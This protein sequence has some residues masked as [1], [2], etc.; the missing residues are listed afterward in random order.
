LHNRT[1][2]FRNSVTERT[3]VWVLVISALF[4]VV[5][6]AA[7]AIP[8]LTTEAILGSIGFLISLVLTLVRKAE[9]ERTF[10]FGIIKNESLLELKYSE[11][12]RGAWSKAFGSWTTS[13]SVLDQEEY[14]QKEKNELESKKKL[15]IRRLIGID[16]TNWT[17]QKLAAHIEKTKKLR[18]E[19]RYDCRLTKLRGL[20][21]AYADYEYQGDPYHKAI[22]IFEGD[23]R[24]VGIFADDR[25]EGE[26]LIVVRAV[27]TIFEEEWERALDAKTITQMNE[28]RI[29]DLVRVLKNPI[30]PKIVGKQG[31]VLREFITDQGKMFVEIETDEGI[32]GQFGNEI[33]IVNPSS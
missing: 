15:R 1:V 12:K 23:G 11:L 3:W 14:L 10:D 21:L 32:H 28:V 18:E 4:V 33:E 31:R 6:L 24:K 27:E 22:V 5:G 16:G 8:I 9:E 19:G 30:N 13:Y 20:E 7:T 25:Q 17:V 29:G 26:Q 2:S